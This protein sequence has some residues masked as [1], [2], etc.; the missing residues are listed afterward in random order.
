MADRVFTDQ[1][2]TTEESWAGTA[3][4]L[5]QRISVAVDDNAIALQYWVPS[6][7]VPATE[8]LWQLWRVSDQTLIGQ[9]DL[10]GLP[11][12]PADALLESD[13]DPVI[14][15]DAADAYLVVYYIRGGDFN[16]GGDTFPLG[17]GNVTAS[18]GIFRNGGA[19]NV[20]PLTSPGD[21]F[22]VYFFAG[23]VTE[24]TAPEVVQV[25]G[26][27]ASTASTAGDIARVAATSGDATAS[28]PLAGDIARV[29]QFAGVVAAVAPTLGDVRRI[30]RMVGTVGATVVLAGRLPGGSDRPG[31]L[32]VRNAGTGLVVRRHVSKLTARL[33]G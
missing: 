13:L 3:R 23:I 33:G 20:Y 22:P 12:P 4:Q 31:G 7:G 6:T 14:P 24:G 21:S 15:L 26:D 9:V 19:N 29:A 30:I 16:D 5:G 1:T 11:T 28:A 8:A 25:S 32:T 2:P 10:L 17:D 18:T 27:V